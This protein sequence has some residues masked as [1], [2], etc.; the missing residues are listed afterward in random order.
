[1]DNIAELYNTLEQ[2]TF[3]CGVQTMKT[4][5]IFFKPFIEKILNN[6]DYTIYVSTWD[7]NVTIYQS[8]WPNHARLQYIH[9]AFNPSLI[10]VNTNAIYF[11][12]QKPVPIP[13]TSDQLA[14]MEYMKNHPT[15]KY[16]FV[17]IIG[18][19][20]PIFCTSLFRYYL[21]FE[22]SKRRWGFMRHIKYVNYK[23]VRQVSRKYYAQQ[24]KKKKSENVTLYDYIIQ[25]DLTMN[26]TSM[27]RFNKIIYKKKTK[28]PKPITN[29]TEPNV[30]TKTVT[31]YIYTN[32]RYDQNNLV[33][34]N[35]T[36]E[37][38]NN[39]VDKYKDVIEV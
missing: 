25:H 14:L 32:I 7:A 26:I 1:M 4:Y 5:L 28:K 9:D 6:S 16:I 29:Q 13:S 37:N 33:M 10:P 30:I 19:L 24:Q 27:Y 35:G 21:H 15:L 11:Y 20:L 34:P 8:V 12:H 3:C 31:K 38:Y 2:S 23:I 18:R 22:V 36:K 17:G 39:M